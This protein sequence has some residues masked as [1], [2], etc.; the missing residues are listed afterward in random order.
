MHKETYDYTL[1]TT[2]GLLLLFIAAILS[3]WAFYM[4]FGYDGTGAMFGQALTSR[5]A[6]FGFLGLGFIAGLVAFEE[7][8]AVLHS[9]KHTAP[10]ILDAEGISA[11]AQPENP[12]ILRLTYK[13]ISD[14]R[15]RAS[16]G[17]RSIEVRHID[18]NLVIPAGAL[19]S[20]EAFDSLLQSL[21]ARVAL[22]RG[23]RY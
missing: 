1:S 14:I 18:G 5:W 19:G 11:P 21:Q 2:K 9:G 16:S 4:A 17:S 15:T 7:V 23:Y 22:T 6:R 10:I 3:L 20:R 13:G 8:K 12:T